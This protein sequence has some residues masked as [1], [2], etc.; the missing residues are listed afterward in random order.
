MS[1]QIGRVAI[2]VTVLF[3]ALFVNLNVITLLQA[4]ELANHPANRRVIVR[5]YQIE[6]GP[7]V[8]GERAI[9]QSVPTDGEFR[10]LRTYPEGALYG[11]LTGYYSIVLQRS[12]L[13]AALN[14]ELTG[15]T[16]EEVAQNLGELLGGSQRAGNSVELTIDDAAQRAARDALDGRTGAVVAL[17]PRTGAV[18]AAYAN[19]SFDPGPLSSHD[20][21]QINEAWGPLRD[22]P[23]QPLLDRTIAE[24]YPP[25]SAFKVVTA[26]AA[27]EHGMEPSE[28]FPDEGVYDVPQTSADI[29]NYGGGPCLDGGDIS[30]HDAMRLSCNTAFA[31]LGVDLG[32]EVLRDQAE[33]FG[34]NLAPPYELD[35]TASVFPR[36]LD[37]PATAQSAIGQRDV[38]AT[39]M[40]MALMAASIANGGEL[41]RPHLVRTVRDPHGQQ[42]RG[43]D[44]GRWTGLPGGGEPISPRTAQQLRD[45]MIDVVETGTGTAAR[46]DGVE[47]GGKTGTAQTGST[48]TT[49]FIGF[50]ADQVAVAVVLPNVGDDATGGATAAPVARAVMAAALG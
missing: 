48:P 3:G 44:V 38:R 13:E 8:V 36:D 28:M 15:R 12:G 20:P 5:E 2:A 14:E 30:L 23:D 9:A 35:V 40:G 45:M 50:A 7:L 19:P 11:H 41:M 18:L 31:R 49:W 42:L 6:R 17:N 34:F 29:G 24:T 33:R 37:V 21:R 39:P 46:I 22:D 43:P 32:E 16:T 10:F 47:V 25:G 4:D 26:A 27:L 1:K